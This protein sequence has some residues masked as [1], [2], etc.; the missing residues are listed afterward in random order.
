MRTIPFNAR[1]IR[2][3][4]PSFAWHSAFHIV[5]H[6]LPVALGLIEKAVFDTITGAAPARLDLWA[7]VALFVGVGVAR[8]A[9]S[10]VDIWHEVAFRAA[11]GIL[12]RRNLLAGLLRRPGAL[13]PPAPAGESL[14]RY[15]NDV[16]EV[17]D[18]PLWIPD[19]VG[20]IVNFAL[21]VA[22]MASINLTITLAIFAPLAVLVLV[23]RAAWARLLRYYEERAE[24]TDKVSGFLGEALGAVQAVKVAGAEG[25]IVARL[26][27]LNERRRRAAVRERLLQD[28]LNNVTDNAVVFGTGVVLLLAGRAMSAGEFT[29]GDF[30]LFT[31][32]LLQTTHLPSYL[33][34][35]IGDYK[36]Q[37]A[38]IRRLT[39][40]LPD[41]P[42]EA[43][44]GQ[45]AGGRQQEA[46]DGMQQGGARGRQAAGR[47]QEAGETSPA[48]ASAPSARPAPAACLLE[49]R[50]LS[51]RHPGGAAGVSDINLDIP[52]GSLTVVTGRVGAGKSTLLRAM[53]GLLPA[54]A[55][56]LRWRGRPVADPAAFFRPPRSAYTAQVARLFS[57]T[58]RENIL[59]GEPAA[60]P[61]LPG[62]LRAAV[63]EPDLATMPQGL[64]TLVGPRGVRL[65]GGQ[66]QRTAAARMLARAPEL[67]VCDDLSSALDVETERLLWE[68]V[69]AW[70]GAH[71]R[72]TIIAVSHR[73][74]L[75]KRADQIVLLKDGRVEAVGRLDELLERSA[76]MRAIYQG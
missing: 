53:L 50:G 7:L 10:F 68:R 55:G 13:P 19:S 26:S 45:E 6:A 17:T 75:L 38:A 46:G 41:E 25:Q 21:A 31:T 30:V 32:Y 60:E 64:D 9:I 35:F 58:L 28:L 40:L 3:A 63:L 57:D 34:T 33:G 51:Y 65:S 43:L 71:L 20:Y 44:V 47:G 62:A 67:L 70:R 59:M 18:F 73:P 39:E 61:N 1:L 5:F 37:E 11:T 29:V 48:P 2:H 72:P 66:T 16:A 74:A 14:S 12:L 56:E 22:I 52:A 8:L 69:A 76:E 27:A 15:R 36:Q 49:V 4:W 24:A 23:S 42:A 54:Q